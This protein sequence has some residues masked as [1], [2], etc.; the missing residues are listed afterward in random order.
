MQNSWKTIYKKKKETAH[1]TQKFWVSPTIGNNP[2]D[3][4]VTADDLPG[5]WTWA[6]IKEYHERVDVTTGRVRRKEG[7]E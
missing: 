6:Q 7:A 4:P 5:Q 1:H 2:Y 3:A